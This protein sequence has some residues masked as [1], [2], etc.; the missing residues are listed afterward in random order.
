MAVGVSFVLV[1]T[2]FA[3]SALGQQ[4]TL[5]RP[6]PAS[7]ALALVFRVRGLRSDRGQVM[8]ALFDRPERWVRAGEE[9]AACH[10]RIRGREARCELTA[11]PGRYAFAFAHDEDG[12]GRFD[13]DFLGIPQEGYGF[14]N[15]VRPSL[16]LPSWQSAAF[17]LRETPSGE[18][19]VTTRYGI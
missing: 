3:G 5:A 17:P 15:N 7:E 13:R 18:L 2:L 16:S 10:V 8:G 12:D 1:L 14:S 19:V 9:V 4:G 11:R 6:A